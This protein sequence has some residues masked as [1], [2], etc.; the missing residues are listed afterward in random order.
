MNKTKNQLLPTQ[1]TLV[2]L[3]NQFVP[4]LLVSNITQLFTQPRERR[5]TLLLSLAKTL[6]SRIVHHDEQTERLLAETPEH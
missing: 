5:S 4:Y 6:A 1:L 3:H 2:N